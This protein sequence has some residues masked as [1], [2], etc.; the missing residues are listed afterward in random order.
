[1]AQTATVNF[2]HFNGLMTDG[3]A[4]NLDTQYAEKCYNCNTSRGVLKPMLSG[5]SLGPLT[6]DVEGE[7][8]PVDAPIGTIM[9]L[10]RR[11]SVVDNDIMVAVAGGNVYYRLSTSTYW[12]QAPLPLGRLITDNNFDFITYERVRPG[13]TDPTDVLLFTNNVDGMFCLWSD[14]FEIDYV[15]IGTTGYRLGAIAR[16]YERVWGTAIKTTEGLA[17]P[18]TLI[19]SQAYDPTNWTDNAVEI[20]D[21]AGEIMQPTWDGDSFVALRTYGNSLLAIKRHGV[22]RVLGTNPSEF[23]VKEQFGGGAVVENTIA[24]DGYMVYMLGDSGIMA[25]DGAEVRPFKPEAIKGVMSRVNKVYIDKAVGVIANNVYYLA[26]PL[27]GSTYNN[28]VLQYNIRESSFNLREG[29]SVRSFLKVNGKLYFTSE[30]SPY[31]LCLLEGGVPMAAYWESGW[32]DLGAASI[33]KSS[34]ELYMAPEAETDVS[35]IVTIKCERRFKQKEVWSS[36][37]KK[38]RRVRFACSGRRFKLILLC[39]TEAYWEMPG[40]IQLNMETDPD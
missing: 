6:I 27:D 8:V 34:F 7:P 28:A 3:P 14:N 21:D 11:F 2:R 1:M 40:G 20:T 37:L 33:T 19:Y 24:V 18:D 26:L 5:V 32:M 15:E 12:T 10:Y 4:M 38:Y 30:T 16:H 25:F 31:D 36:T 13:D 29:T 17:V 9:R 23:V 22:W 39:P 35:F